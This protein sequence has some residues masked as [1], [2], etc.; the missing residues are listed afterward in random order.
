MWVGEMRILWF[1]TIAIA[2]T[3]GILPAADLRAGRGVVKITPPKGTP[4]AGYYYV[5]LNTGTHDDLYAKAIVFEKEGVKAAMVACD[6]V[7]M[8]RTVVETARARIESG[9]GIPGSRVMISATHSH[10]GPELGMRLKGVDTQTEQIARNYVEE[11]PGKIADAVKLADADLQSARLSAGIGHETAI[12]FIRRYHMT[13]G[14]VGWN[15]GKL[16]P[17]IVGPTSTI[18][19][20]VPVV[21]LDTPDGKPLATYVNFANHLDTVGGLE[22]SADYAYTLSKLLGE[23]KGPEMLTV[24]TIG[25]AGNINHIDVKSAAPQKGNQEAERIGTI[26]AADVLKTFRHLESVN[27]AGIRTGSRILKLKPAEYK[28]EEVDKA[29]SIVAAYG[30]PNASP[31]NDQVNAFKVL[32][33]DA[34]KG[35]PLEAEVQVIALGRDV[36]WV[37]LP[38]KIFVEHGKAIKI[39]S[40]FKFT[41]IAELANGSLGYVP[42]RKAYPEG[43]Y[44]VISARVAPEAARLWLR[45]PSICLSRLTRA[46]KMSGS[47]PCWV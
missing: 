33:L 40:P 47:T 38:G 10:T 19:P 27:A 13:D 43:A 3:A 12:S 17:K 36:A 9:T 29:R 20:D 16:N 1:W 6:L 37:G 34:R 44:E 14:T 26:L 5:R 18:D 32:D 8:P 30:K 7:T 23:I 15:P 42:D 41:I 25:A 22:Y 21:Y 11:L 35:Q 2:A 39:A 46:N 4:M 45:L 28:P 24:F 31:F